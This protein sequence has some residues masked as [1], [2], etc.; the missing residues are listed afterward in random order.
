ML[1]GW[2]LDEAAA[3]VGA[4]LDAVGEPVL[5]RAWQGEAG[6]PPLPVY[7]ETPIHALFT[8]VPPGLVT[9]GMY[10][11]TDLQLITRVPVVPGDQV[12]RFGKSY[13]VLDAPFAHRVSDRVLT[14]ETKVREL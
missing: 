10:L 1:T 13:Q 14:Y 12:V 8:P 5:L 3:M 4:I 2:D 7:T 9:S 11:K 6:D